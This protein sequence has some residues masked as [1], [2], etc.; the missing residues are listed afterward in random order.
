MDTTLWNH[1][2]HAPL[3]PPLVLHNLSSKDLLDGLGNVECVLP[4]ATPKN[5]LFVQFGGSTSRSTPKPTSRPIEVSR[6]GWVK[7]VSCGG[8]GGGHRGGKGRQ[9]QQCEPS[10][11][12]TQCSRAGWLNE[13]T[14]VSGRGCHG[15][16]LYKHI[17]L[18]D[19]PLW[20][21][22]KGDEPYRN[23]S[24]VTIITPCCRPERLRSVMASIRFEYVA[25]W[26]IVYDANK[27]SHVTPL[28]VDNPKISEY[29]LSPA[30]FA[31][32][33][34]RNFAMEHIRNPD[35]MLYFLD[36][37]NVIHPRLYD[38]LDI[39]VPMRC[40]SFDQLRLDRQSGKAKVQSGDQYLL[41]HID[42]AMI[43]VDA[44]LASSVRWIENYPWGADGVFISS[45]YILKPT[46]FVYVQQTLCY[47]NGLTLPGVT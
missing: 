42:T 46:R 37:D 45:L 7:E 22:T 16:E 29:A 3:L 27:V 14:E 28:S 8:G 18:D 41:T 23:S 44:R 21:W 34:Q 33:E 4:E 6:T 5:G 26:I 15:W 31:G 19:G 38:L 40:Y 32:N 39:A 13:E 2:P 35:T 47:H 11:T 30:G 25:E 9:C 24:L 36:D 10:T 43:L 20:L 12:T 1:Q 17:I